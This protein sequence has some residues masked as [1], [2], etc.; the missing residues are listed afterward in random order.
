MR[1]RTPPALIL[2]LLTASLAL[3][4]PAS[5][6]NRLG[7]E[8]EGLLVQDKVIAGISGYVFFTDMIGVD[9]AFQLMFLDEESPRLGGTFLGGLMSAHLVFGFPI[10]KR[11]MI[12]V[13]TGIDYYGLWG[14]DDEEGKAAMPLLAEARVYVTNGLSAF[15]QPRFYLFGSDGLEPGVA[16]DGEETVPLVIAVGVGGEWR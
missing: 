14:V 5:A 8:A 4:A 15:I 12:R 16:A 7:L 3:S 11:A 1:A 13:G 6:A 10:G 2:A 9:A